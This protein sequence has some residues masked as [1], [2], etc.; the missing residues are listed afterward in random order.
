M[1]ASFIRERFLRID[2]SRKSL[3][4]YKLMYG[5]KEN[6]YLGYS[7]HFISSISY[8]IKTEMEKYIQQLQ[9]NSNFAHITFIH[10][11]FFYQ[12]FITFFAFGLANLEFRYPLL[13]NARIPLYDVRD[14]GK[15]V[16]ECFRQPTKWGDGQIVP[17]VAEQL[18]M[19]QICATIRDVT[20]KDVHFVPLSYDEA[21]LRLHRE[22]V[23][24]LRWYNDIGSIDGQ[25]AEETKK[26][27][28]QMNTF[29]GWLRE[30][31][32]LME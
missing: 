3:T 11:S 32:W 27:W 9:P 18:T 13:S 16:R 2:G 17:I 1:R 23:K 14:T 25:Q 6:A 7:E 4:K 30:N 10:G 29:A 21:L 15:V 20:G 28:S 31:Q 22:T 26:I 24:N 19:E 8:S 12:N 5:R